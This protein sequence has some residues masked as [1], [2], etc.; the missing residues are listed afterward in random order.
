[1]KYLIFSLLL[2][3]NFSAITYCQ[4]QPQEKSPTFT[5]G[6]NKII[7]Y[8][9]IP[10]ATFTKETLF[11]NA[12]QWYT[13]NFET[14]D[15]TLIINNINDGILSG[16]GIIH[17]NKR[18]QK[19]EP[20]DVFFTIDMRINNGLYTYTVHDLYG[21]DNTGKFYYSDMYNED[22]YPSDKPKWQ[23]QYR[24]TTLGNMNSKILVMITEL[25]KEMI[26]PKLEK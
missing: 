10:V 21:F 18:D 14:A 5:L 24:R 12:Q 11:A 9:S 3:L 7:Y 19:A 25:Q 23:A 22:Q 15:N 2:I 26:T 6:D 20:G 16:T 17:Q 13:K 4:E 1:M 8:A